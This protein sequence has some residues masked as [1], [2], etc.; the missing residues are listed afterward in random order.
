MTTVYHREYYDRLLIAVEGH[1]GF[2]ESGSDIV[3]AGVSALTYTLLNCMLDEEAAGNIKLIRNI[4]RDGYIHLE[5][6]CF[7]FSMERIKGMFD[8]CVT[9]LLMLEENYPEFVS[10]R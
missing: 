1:S 8:A 5:I 7:D 10:F 4:V 9:G 2:S 6:E 3:C